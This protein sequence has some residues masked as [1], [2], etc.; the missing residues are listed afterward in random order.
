MFK[1]EFSPSSQAIENAVQDLS[2]SLYAEKGGYYLE[3]NMDI[4]SKTLRTYEA[5]LDRS[6]RWDGE[7]KFQWRVPPYA[8][9][10]ASAQME[11][12]RKEQVALKEEC[13]TKAQEAIKEFLL[14]QDEKAKQAPEPEIAGKATDAA[15]SKD[16]PAPAAANV[17]SA[18]TTAPATSTAA[19][20]EDANAAKVFSGQGTYTEAPQA[21][22]SPTPQ[23]A[24]PFSASGRTAGREEH[25]E[26]QPLKQP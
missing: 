12:Y 21:S 4:M 5:D 26:L 15:P 6:E 9:L 1:A 23:G 10:R 11:K 25:I 17:A 14:R 2:D 18:S 13:R 8:A 7:G 16:S 20:G 19:I 24:A 22:E 3:Q